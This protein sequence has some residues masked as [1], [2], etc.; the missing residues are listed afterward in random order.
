KTPSRIEVD[1]SISEW[2]F[3]FVSRLPQRCFRGHSPAAANI[4]KR[5]RALARICHPDRF[6]SDALL[7]TKDEQM[8][9]QKASISARSREADRRARSATFSHGV[10]PDLHPLL[11]SCS[12]RRID[13]CEEDHHW[14]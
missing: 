1:T 13:H 2:S 3:L 6:H 7:L 9:L 12:V 14:P 4:A 5:F 10:I 11:H 8:S